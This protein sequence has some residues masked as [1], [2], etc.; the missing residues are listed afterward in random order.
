MQ[1][2]TF[3]YEKWEAKVYRKIGNVFEIWYIFAERCS[4]MRSNNC[5]SA[6]I[7][8]QVYLAEICL[9]TINSNEIFIKIFQ[10]IYK[11][12]YVRTEIYKISLTIS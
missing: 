2:K 1:Y 4:L 10:E 5:F 6:L 12:E 3:K 8:D 7:K 9:P 11:N